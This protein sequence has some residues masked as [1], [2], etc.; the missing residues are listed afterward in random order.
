MKKDALT[1]KIPVPEGIQVNIEGKVVSVKGPKGELKRELPK[2]ISAKKGNNEIILE[3]TSKKRKTFASLK[4][5]E[6]I[7]QNNIKGANKEF[8][9]QLKIVFS[10]FPINV[11]VKG[12]LVEINNFLGGKRPRTAKI[13]PGAKVEVKGKDIFTRASSKEAAGQTA[14][15]IES[16]AKVSGRDKRIF[17]DG[18]FIVKKGAE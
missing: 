16:A 10:H 12:N 14:A 1:V 2:E 4:S 7:L 11:A 17:Q 9:Y 5:L 3:A 15:N 6:K 8:E 18:I 13:V